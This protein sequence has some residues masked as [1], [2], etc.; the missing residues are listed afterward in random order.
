MDFRRAFLS[1]HS[2]LRPEATMDDE[3]LIHIETKLAHQ[4]L[5]ID[6]LNQVIYKQ[7]ETI[8]QLEKALKIL[9]KQVRPATG[10][11]NEKPPH[12]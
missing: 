9:I 10:P 1:A 11:A 2:V 12:Y 6:E 3:R 7:Q 8:D 5:L 4:E